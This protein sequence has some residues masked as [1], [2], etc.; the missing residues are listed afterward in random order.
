MPF[1]VLAVASAVFYGAADFLGGLTSKRIDTNLVVLISQGAGLVL[2]TIL[3]PIMSP[4]PGWNDWIWGGVAGLTGGIGVALLYRA[5]A[6]GVM[7]VIAPI[8]AVCAVVIPVFVAVLLGERPGLQAVA[9]I[10]LAIVAIVLVSQQHGTPEVA[11]PANKRA[12]VGLAFASGV[13]IGLFFLAL[14]RTSP[15]AGLWP[16]LSARVVSVALFGVVT[17]ATRPSFEMPRNAVITAICAGLIDM[18]AN[19][20]YLLASRGGPLTIVVTLTSLYPAST[21]ILARMILGERLT[22]GQWA[23]VACALAAI[24]AIVGA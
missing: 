22:T 6:I 21:V 24:V 10:V 7:A 23:G 20:L 1:V 16:L 9:G 5:L 17:I 15:D 13:A 18:L 4:V 14:A 2:V 3:S 8:T 12:G 19:L 11:S